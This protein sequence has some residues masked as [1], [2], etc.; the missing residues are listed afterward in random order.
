M[1][2]L[3]EQLA[4]DG[5]AAAVGV[6]GAAG[7]AAAAPDSPAAYGV[8]GLLGLAAA[9]CELGPAWDGTDA[10]REQLMDLV[11]LQTRALLRTFEAVAVAGGDAMPVIMGELHAASVELPAWVNML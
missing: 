8:A 5:A 3:H 2:E 10:G 4:D 1:D 7:A 6:E 11:A 9:A